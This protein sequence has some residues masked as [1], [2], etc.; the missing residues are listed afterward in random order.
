MKQP[1]H[2][3][4]VCQNLRGNDDPRGS[5]MRR[6]SQEV[7]DHLK[8]RR[9]ALGLKD[10]L[11]VMGASCLGACESG[12]T[13]LVVDGRGATFYGRVDVD[14]AEAILQEHVLGAAADPS[15]A[16]HRLPADD[17]LDLSALEGGGGGEGAGEA[18]GD[19]EGD[20]E[21]ASA[22]AGPTRPNRPTEGEPAP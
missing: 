9:N 21:P 3:I 4:F 18:S 8:T 12:I 7:L 6:G 5:C 22:S 10:S 14:S 20:R 2:L 16:R 1:T 13:T 19:V 11:R 17:L 15:L